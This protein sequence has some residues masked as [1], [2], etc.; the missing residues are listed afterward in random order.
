MKRRAMATL[1]ASILLGGCGEMGEAQIARLKAEALRNDPSGLWSIAV[2][3]EVRPGRPVLICADRQVASGFFSIVPAAG[4]QECRRD[5]GQM[6]STGVGM[7]YRCRL[8]K[9]DY[10]VSSV[11]SGD[12]VR[13]FVVSSS[14]YPIL[15]PGPAYVRSLRFRRMGACPAG[16][17]VG[18]AT[19]QRGER[20][21]AIE[22]DLS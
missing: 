11:T 13:D 12:P 19:N 1:G 14:A 18:D 5:P 2:E 9:V 17:K 7:R 22:P 3:G 8:N 20:V 4:G 6:K 16:W 21:R 15:D 10:A